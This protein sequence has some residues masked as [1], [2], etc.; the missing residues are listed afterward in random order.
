M[1]SVV[2]LAATRFGPETV[3]ED[4]RRAHPQLLQANR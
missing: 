2:R 1:A 4:I 3:P